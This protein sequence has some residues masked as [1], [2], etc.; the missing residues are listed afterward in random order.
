MGC[1]HV[2]FTT[3]GVMRCEKCRG[4]VTVG[5]PISIKDFEAISRAFIKN[6]KNC[7]E[8]TA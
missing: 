4:T 1:D 7:K 5:F 8:Q 2:V 3:D 6:H